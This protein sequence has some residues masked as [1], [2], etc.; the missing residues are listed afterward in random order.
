MHRPGIRLGV[1]VEMRTTAV[2]AGVAV[3]VAV[4]IGFLAGGAAAGGDE[5]LPSKATPTT[6]KGVA[7][8]I[9]PAPTGPKGPALKT[10][11]WAA[12]VAFLGLAGAKDPDHSF[13][14]T[15]A[16]GQNALPPL[17]RQHPVE[18]DAYIGAK[19]PQH[20]GGFSRCRRDRRRACLLENP[21]PARPGHLLLDLIERRIARALAR[22]YSARI[23]Q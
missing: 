3:V 10:G 16:A 11:G 14:V 8:Q 15:Q 1:V 23:R 13:E 19:T 9:P 22:E 18:S 4:L 21:P 2:V 20:H 12:A 7:K 17:C 5:G 6:S